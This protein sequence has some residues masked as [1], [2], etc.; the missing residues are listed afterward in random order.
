MREI[1]GGRN[2]ITEVMDPEGSQ[3]IQ[4]NNILEVKTLGLIVEIVIPLTYIS[5]VCYIKSRCC[6]RDNNP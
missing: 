5:K 4:K 6:N 3:C 1:V 2:L